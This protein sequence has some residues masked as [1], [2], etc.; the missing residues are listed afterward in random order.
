[1]NK[2]KLAQRIAADLT[3]TLE[4]SKGTI[5]ECVLDTLANLMPDEVF[6]EKELHYWAKGKG[7]TPLS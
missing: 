2:D 6:D 7:Y 1:M 4:I 3:S 5:V